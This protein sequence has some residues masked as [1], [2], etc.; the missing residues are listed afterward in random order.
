MRQKGNKMLDSA[1][2]RAFV[3]IAIILIVTWWRSDEN[4][5]FMKFQQT[6]QGHAQ[7]MANA[8][9]DH[10]QAC[11]KAAKEGVLGPGCQA[12]PTSGREKVLVIPPTFPRA[13]NQQQ[14]QP[15]LYQP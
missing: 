3:G 6:P 13:S 9:I 1:T 15:W 2:S 14:P 10:V 4:D 12:A 5:K 7:T 8:Q 11:R